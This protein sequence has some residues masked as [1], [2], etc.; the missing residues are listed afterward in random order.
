MSE[1]DNARKVG[2]CNQC[3][4]NNISRGY[5]L[6]FFGVFAISFDT[7][8]I[9]LVDNIDIWV[10]IFYRYLLYSGMSFLY[11][12]FVERCNIFR[13]IYKLGYQGLFAIAMISTCNICFTMSINYIG[14]ATTLSIFAVSPIMTSLLSWITFKQ[15]MYIWTKIILVLITSILI[16]CNVL[17]VNEESMIKKEIGYLF[18]VIAMLTT[19]GYFTILSFNS[20]HNPNKKMVLTTFIS[21]FISSII[22]LIAIQDYNNL[23]IDIESFR[24]I[25]LQGLIVL[26]IAFISF[27]NSTKYISGTESNMILILEIVL[28][29]VWVFLA[30]IETPNTLSIIS[31][32]LV[33]VLLVLNSILSIKRKR[34]EDS[35]ESIYPKITEV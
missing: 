3:L 22:S 9:K 5:L 32:C 8:L 20:V 31:I 16:I 24:W 17:N 27:T 2:I 7:L 15:E 10:L 1:S 29:P 34:I 14:V 35:S 13:E 28:G 11:N 12:F 23:D 30:G 6:A 21:G 18:A 26:P 33:V 4:E 19:A 25:I